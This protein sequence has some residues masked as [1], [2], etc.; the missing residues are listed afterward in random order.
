MCQARRKLR[1]S[2][3]EQAL[4]MLAEMGLVRSKETK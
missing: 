4:V 1:A 2:T 3:T